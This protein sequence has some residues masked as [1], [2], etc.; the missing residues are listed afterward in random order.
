MSGRAEYQ[1]V[2]ARGEYGKDQILTANSL[3]E[4]RKKIEAMEGGDY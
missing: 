2:Q 3:T 1:V 4:L